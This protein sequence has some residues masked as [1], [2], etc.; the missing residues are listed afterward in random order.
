MGEGSQPPTVPHKEPPA[1][2]A[3]QTES[4]PLCTATKKQN[5]CCFSP[6][7][8]VWGVT[9]Q[10]GT[11]TRTE[12]NQLC[13]REST[14]PTGVKWQVGA[15]TQAEVRRAGVRYLRGW[16]ERERL[17]TQRTGLGHTAWERKLSLPA[18]GEKT[19]CCSRITTRN[20]SG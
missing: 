1:R 18:L 10:S 7:V 4:K 16:P 15:G 2:P 20:T 6:R 14:A 9:Q 5:N 8:W 12:V 13:K 17:A 3:K 19:V 11:R